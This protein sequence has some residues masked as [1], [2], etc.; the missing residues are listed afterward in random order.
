MSDPWLQHDQSDAVPRQFPS[1]WLVAALL[2]ASGVLWAV[3][4]F[5]PLAHLS[6]FAGGAAPFDVRPFG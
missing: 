3:M 6:Q 2:W 4:F 1:G 5:G